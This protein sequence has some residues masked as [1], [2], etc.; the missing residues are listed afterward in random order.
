[1]YVSLHRIQIALGTRDTG[2]EAFAK[3]VALLDEEDA[4]LALRVL[5]TLGEAETM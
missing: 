4:A 5:E 1:M 3:G 2:P